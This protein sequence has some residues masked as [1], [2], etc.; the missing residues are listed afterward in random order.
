MAL[1][2]A[3]IAWGMS[4]L[5]YA[6]QPDEIAVRDWRALAIADVEAAYAAFAQEHPGYY[7]PANPGF[8]D[9]LEKARSGALA[10]AERVSKPEDYSVVLDAFSSAFRDGH[11]VVFPTE[12]YSREAPETLRWP[13]FIANWRG[14]K[15][16][17]TRSASDHARL[18]GAEVISCDGQPIR[19]LVLRNV[20]SLR[21]RPDEPGQWWRRAHNLFL[22]SSHS[23][24]DL[25]GASLPATCLLQQANG[26]R[27]RHK[28]TWTD[29]PDE[30]SGSWYRES[31]I[32]E[33][34]PI[35]L[36]EPRPGLFLIG[37]PDF[38]PGAEGQAAYEVLFAD[39]AARKDDLAGARAIF[40][41]MRGN[42]GGSSTWPRQ[43]AEHLWGE[44]FM[45]AAMDAY[46]ADVRI[47]WRNTPAVRAVVDTYANHPEIPERFRKSLTK[48]SLALAEAPDGTPLVLEPRD[49]ENDRSQETPAP[50]MPHIPVYIASDG[51]C[52]SSCNNGLDIFTRFPGARLIGAPSSA[53]STYLEVRVEP[54]GSGYAEMVL[55]MKIWVDRPARPGPADTY[56]PDIPVTSADWSTK[57]FLDLIERDVAASQAKL[58]R[59]S[60]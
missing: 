22:A 23:G 18:V 25:I 57:T 38:S 7:D 49:E 6:Q 4:A 34:T 20:F 54:T 40:I 60:D 16:L 2:A 13:G 28:L 55:P 19:D 46:H 10:L 52:A 39:L 31:F 36:S 12:A 15:M 29:I 41:D 11:A 53:D 44:P 42:N 51:S 47:L 26:K 59:I 8:R 21:Y 24:F 33:T 5:A 1:A 43:V 27:I 58:P 17:V 32:G 48:L 9:Q 56:A 3:M 45:T 37:L 50:L 30:V 14:S 35:G